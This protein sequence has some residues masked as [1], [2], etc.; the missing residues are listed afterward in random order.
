MAASALGMTNKESY[1]LL[2]FGKIGND[3]G[4]GGTVLWILVSIVL[5]L[6]VLAFIGSGA[7]YIMLRKK[8]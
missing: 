4:G 3:L 6:L 8:R 7:L 2:V 5:L 1:G